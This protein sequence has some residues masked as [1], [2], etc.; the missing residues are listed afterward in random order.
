[1]YLKIYFVPA[2]S[3]RGGSRTKETTRKFVTREVRGCLAGIRFFACGQTYQ[4]P[5]MLR[6]RTCGQKR[7]YTF[8]SSAVLYAVRG[9]DGMGGGPESSRTSSFALTRDQCKNITF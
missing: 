7:I 8:A 2:C 5:G 9:W 3:N 1:M 4:D 6:H